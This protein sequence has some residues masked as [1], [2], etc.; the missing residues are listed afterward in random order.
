[1]IKKHDRGQTPHQRAVKHPTVRRMPV[2]RMDA[3][4]KQIHPAALSRQILALTGRL[5]TIAIAKRPAPVKPAVN[6][7]WNHRRHTEIPS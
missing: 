1:M 7:A 6:S 4:F 2:I 3:Q 5:E